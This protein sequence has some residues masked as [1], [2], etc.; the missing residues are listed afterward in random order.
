MYPIPKSPYYFALDYLPQELKNFE[1]GVSDVLTNAQ[2]LAALERLRTTFENYKG[3]ATDFKNLVDFGQFF[4]W[5][6]RDRLSP[7]R[8]TNFNSYQKNLIESRSGGITD[9]FTNFVDQ[10]NIIEIGAAAVLTA[11]GAAAVG[12]ISGGAAATSAS[13]AITLPSAT[14]ISLPSL[15]QVGAAIGAAASAE[16]QKRAEQ[17]LNK[18][19]APKIPIKSEQEISNEQMI[20]EP[21]KNNF[22]L[23]AGLGL[24]SILIFI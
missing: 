14:T 7:E 8:L 2:L 18:L 15:G 23:F 11:T 6:F 16:L 13:A 4:N 10:N 20:T 9:Q 1:S 19:I 5:Q 21:V 3:S 24:L 12:T 22:P 17:E